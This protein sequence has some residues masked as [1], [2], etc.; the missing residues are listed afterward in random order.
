MQDIRP[1]MKRGDESSATAA[2]FLRRRVERPLL[3]LGA[4]EHQRK[5]K[6]RNRWLAHVAAAVAVL[7]H[8][9][10][11]LL[12]HAAA[13]VVSESLGTWSTA[14]L[15]EARW[16]LAA[17]SLPKQGLAIFAGGAGTLC[18]CYCDDCREACGVKGVWGGVEK[19]AWEECCVLRARCDDS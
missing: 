10:C 4:H 13:Q 5:P 18:D 6:R 7:L 15:S 1:G 2:Q 3:V 8:C 14:S 11:S 17:T 12:V 9:A 19:H 16:W